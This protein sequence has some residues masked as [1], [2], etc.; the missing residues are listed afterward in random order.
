MTPIKWVYN[1]DTQFVT[2]KIITYLEAQATARKA[3]P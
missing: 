3:K 2:N 1:S